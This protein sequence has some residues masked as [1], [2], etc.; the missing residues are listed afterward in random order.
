MITINKLFCKFLFGVIFVLN[1]SSFFKQVLSSEFMSLYKWSQSSVD[2]SKKKFIR[3]FIFP[4]F[5]I[6][7]ITVGVSYPFLIM[8]L[9]IPLSLIVSLMIIRLFF[10]MEKKGIVR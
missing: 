4:S 6:F 10:Y 7:G 2:E 8:L 5:L 1:G 9:M 3:L